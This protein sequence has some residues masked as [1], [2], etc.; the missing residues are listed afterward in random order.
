MWENELHRESDAV[1]DT[2]IGF[3]DANNG[4]N[5]HQIAATGADYP[6]PQDSGSERMLGIQLYRHAICCH[7]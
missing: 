6:M 1:K 3:E 5:F 2:D 4:I 7:I